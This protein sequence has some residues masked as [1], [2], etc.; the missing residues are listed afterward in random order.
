[1]DDVNL[2]DI[3]LNDENDQLFLYDILKF[4]WLNKEKIN[5]KYKS[6]EEI[7]SFEEHVNFLKSGYFKGIYKVLLFDEVIGSASIDKKNF[8]S[9][10]YLPSLLKKA[11]RKYDIK[12][13]N[14]INKKYY[15][16]HKVEDIIHKKHPDVK[17]HFSSANPLNIS[18]LKTMEDLGYKCIEIV[19]AKKLD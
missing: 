15:I 14:K 9:I 4:R 11:I 3:N 10:F 5:I 16:S 17:I 19:F 7:P 2:L 12:K 8:H 18:S 6:K 13:I 1:M